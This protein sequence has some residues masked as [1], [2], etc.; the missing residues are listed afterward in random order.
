MHTHI[1]L[2]SLIFTAYGEYEKNALKLNIRIF[3]AIIR[4]MLCYYYPP[5]L[6]YVL[7]YSFKMNK[8]NMKTNL[9]LCFH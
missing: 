4:A 8:Q 3:G 7:I 1:G 5:F 2:F 9:S 6:V